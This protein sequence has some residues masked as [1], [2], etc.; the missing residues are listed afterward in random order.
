MFWHVVSPARNALFPH[1]YIIIYLFVHVSGA[2]PWGERKREGGKRE[3]ERGRERGGQGEFAVEDMTRGRM[4]LPAGTMTWFEMGE[5]EAWCNGMRW[6]FYM[7]LH[8]VTCHYLPLLSITEHYLPFLSITTTA[9]HGRRT[10][11]KTE[12]GCDD[13]NINKYIWEVRI[14]TDHQSFK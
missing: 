10:R 8:T 1:S 6:W 2:V 9:T 3:W 12:H 4:L 14:G 11:I 5:C 13:I 7:L